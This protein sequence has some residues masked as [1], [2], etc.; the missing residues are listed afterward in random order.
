MIKYR[1]DYQPP[2]CRV[3]SAG[4]DISIFDERTFVTTTLELERVGDTPFLLNGRDLT[5]HEISINGVLLDADDWPFVEAGLQFENLPP[6]SVLRIKS[7]C[8]P[9]SNTALEGLYLS[10]GMYCTQCE[11]EGFRRMAFFP[12]R[13]DV[14]TI[15]T[16]RIEAE[17]RF[18]QLLSNG[19]L[20]ETGEIDAGRH[21]ALWHDPHP[22]PSYLFAAVVGDLDLAA[23]RFVTASGRT[24]DLHIYVEKGNVELTGHAMDSLKRSMKWDEDTYGLEYDLDLF[25]IV[26]VSH[27]NMGAMENKGLNIFNSKFVLADPQT[28]TDEDLDRVESIVAHEYFHNWTGNRVTC[29]DWFQLTLKEG[30]T[31]YRDQCFSADMHDEGVQR[32]GDVS[33][34]RAAQ[35]PE[36]RS[37]T[38]HPIRPESY[39]EINN[40]YTPTIYEK[41]AEVIR[42]MAGYLGRDGFRRGIDL[43]FERHDGNAVT[44]DDFVAALADANAQDMSSFQGWYSQAGTP[45]L[46]ISRVHGDDGLTLTLEQTVPET[47]AETPR[48][49]LPVPVRVGFVGSDGSPVRLRLADADAA[50]D[51]HVMLLTEKSAAY[52]FVASDGGAVDAGIIPSALRGFSAPVQLEDDLSSADR[53]HLMAHDSDL[54]N[55]WDSAQMLTANAILEMAAGKSPDIAPLAAGF[56]QILDDDGVLNEFKAGCLRLPG[57]AVL[58]AA[59]QPADPVSLFHARIALQA[60]LGAALGDKIGAA[61]AASADLASSAG[62]RA[63]LTHLLEFG[64]AAG[65]EAAI[66]AAEAMVMD[67]N[68]TLSQGGLKALIHT[69]NDARIRALAAF[70]DRWQDD[71]LVMEKWFQMESMSSVG[72]TIARLVELMQHPAFDPKN[73]NKMRAILGAFMMGNVPRFHAADGSGYRFVAEQLVRI[74][75]RNGQLAAR[76]ALPLSRMAGYDAGRQAAMREALKIVQKGATSSDLREVVDKAL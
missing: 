51:E 44:C 73:P 20:I 24:V 11:P 67:A 58:E 45:H 54:F 23:D 70:H 56:R 15:F 1:A 17:K 34:L 47:A 29:R 72:G 57:L 71:P 12:D 61:L 36:D 19:N 10:G 74:D 27:F 40:F 37:P 8:H 65:D 46:K 4:L 18:P 75:A 3:A 39:R 69:G 33:M 62:G 48:E 66:I 32:A 64:V 59:R 60:A 5:V 26:A 7:E 30:L 76:M 42:M 55:R 68:M 13:P 50:R 22:K 25:Q 21:Y 43:Y 52:R 28:A 14:M 9:Q 16:V 6:Q 35:F 2:S 49:P 63:L 41:G 53:L 31:V 38:A